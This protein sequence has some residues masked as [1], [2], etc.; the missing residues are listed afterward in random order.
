MSRWRP[1]VFF[2]IL[3]SMKKFYL[4]L[5]LVF[6]FG[7]TKPDHDTIYQVATLQALA[8][9]NYDG[10]VTCGTLKTKGNFGIG[11][12]D[13]LDGEMVYLDRVIYQIKSNG[14]VYMPADSESIPFCEITNFETDI[15]AQSKT[16]QSLDDLKKSIDNMLPNKNLFYA[17]KIS[18]SFAYLKTRSVPKQQKPYP[19]LVEVAKDQPEFEFQNVQG[20]LV[21]FW[22]PRYAENINLP[23]YHFHF[24]SDDKTCGGHV[25]EGIVENVTI[26]IDTTD[27]F[28]LTIPQDQKT[29][30]NTANKKEI[31]AIEK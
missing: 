3:N 10:A 26:Q 28:N 22:F 18:G 31:E 1:S 17:I 27:K 25:L 2:A 19:L 23:A 24:L 6:C 20:T 16:R 9:G 11:T 7:C 30:L 15:T 4:I 12:F 14:H 5:L 21:G 13:A 29:E 8:Q